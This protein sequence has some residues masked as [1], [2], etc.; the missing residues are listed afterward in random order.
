VNRLLAWA[1]ANAQ[2]RR[3]DPSVNHY[4]PIRAAS[5][6]G[7]AAVVAR[8]LQDPRVD[9]NSKYND[10]VEKAA[11]RGHSAVV[12]VLLKD[13]RVN[14]SNNAIISATIRG[15]VAVIDRLLQDPR[16]DPCA[17]D[18]HI[19]RLAHSFGHKGVIYRLLQDERVRA[20]WKPPSLPQRKQVQVQT[21]WKVANSNHFWTKYTFISIKILHTRQPWTTT[22]TPKFPN[23]VQFFTVQHLFFL[24][25]SFPRCSNT[26]IL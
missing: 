17:K 25:L 23:S 12:D 24:R 14:L 4:R 5:E 1:S 26:F 21:R 19:L 8:L 7:H 6:N 11:A 18:N 10:L 16:F 13:P 22:G 2:Y 15:N 20:T 3:V 9:P